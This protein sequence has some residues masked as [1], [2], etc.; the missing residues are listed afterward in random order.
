MAVV[1]IIQHGDV[2]SPLAGSPLWA[3]VAVVVDRTQAGLMQ[4]VWADC[5]P[6]VRP[7]ALPRSA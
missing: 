3:A 2:A 6:S 4:A 5:K 7:H 1:A